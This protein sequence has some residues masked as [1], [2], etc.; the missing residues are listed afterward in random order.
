M[1][2]MSR[3]MKSIGRRMGREER[4]QADEEG[5]GPHDEP[6][7]SDHAVNE[8]A[9]LA[10][11]GFSA[12][13]PHQQPSQHGQQQPQVVPAR[14]RNPTTAAHTMIVVMTVA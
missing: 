4:Q 10:L 12:C 9:D 13:E 2:M 6:D 5:C 11:G 3:M 8:R 7:I 1:P 14:V